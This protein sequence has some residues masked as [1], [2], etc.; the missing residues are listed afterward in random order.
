MADSTAAS[1]AQG[2]AIDPVNRRA[3]VSIVGR[4]PRGVAE[5]R[6]PGSAPIARANAVVQLKVFAPDAAGDS[7]APVHSS[8]ALGDFMAGAPA[9]AARAGAGGKRVAVVPLTAN[10]A[11]AV[12]DAETGAGIRVVPFGVAPFA[13]VLSGDGAVAYVSNV[14]GTQPKAGDRSARQCCDPRAEAVRI[15]ARGIAA[16]ERSRASTSR[17]AV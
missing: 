2:I 4:L 14:G 6:L 5:S 15:D 7:V 9:I 11:L 8:G 10:D 17:A 3:L 12:L 16:A 1:G 13:A